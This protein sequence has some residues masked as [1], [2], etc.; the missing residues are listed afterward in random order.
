ME[1][2]LWA[3]LGLISA[4]LST[5][6]F[7]TQERLKLPGFVCAFWNKIACAAF[8]LPFVIYFGAPTNPSF[9]LILV[10]Q[11]VLWV[12]SDVIFFGTITKVGAGLVSRILPVSVIITFFLWFA[13]DPSTLEKYLSTPVLSMA[14]V[15]ALCSSVYFAMRLKH[16][17]VSWAAVQMI[18]F[19]IFAA[20]VGPMAAKLVM[21]QS[22]F[23]QG[24]FAYVFFEAL[25]MIGMWL[26]YYAIKKPVAHNVMFNLNAV[27]GGATIGVFS[28][29]MVASNVAAL[30]LVDNPGLLPAVKFTDTFLILLY[31]K[32]IGRKEQSD[33][34]AGIGIVACAAVIIIL[35][36]L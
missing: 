14:V 5:G 9:Y 10:A 17:P 7:L 23:R 18:W 2:P 21:G 26:V 1:F 6:V 15:L 30:Q 31:Y 25:A 20:V 36:S 3:G 22:T 33:V 8:A 34:I 24:P 19:V 11:A 35:K 12:I 29:L 4:T 13:V 32:W 28:F 16:C 27:K